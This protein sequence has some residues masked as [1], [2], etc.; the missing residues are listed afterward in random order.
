MGKEIKCDVCGAP[1][2]V[3]LTQIIGN[4]IHKINLCEAC[5]QKLGVMDPGG[6]SLADLIDKGLIPAPDSAEADDSRSEHACPSCGLTVSQLNKTG[7]L[8]CS[9]C[10]EALEEE[11]LPMLERMQPGIQHSGKVPEAMLERARHREEMQELRD[12]LNGAISEERYE[13]AA[14]IRDEIR[15]LEVSS[16]N[17]EVDA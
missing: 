13:E 4:K 2:T 17:D 16:G 12:R 7:R 3:H 6:Y 1:A 14:T 9:E 15:D 11:V 8:G 10:F 5:A